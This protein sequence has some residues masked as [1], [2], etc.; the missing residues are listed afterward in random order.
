MSKGTSV[1][2]TEAAAAD[3]G[4]DGGGVDE[5]TALGAADGVDESSGAGDWF[6]GGAESGGGVEP[7]AATDAGATYGVEV[8]RRHMM[9]WH[10][11]S[12]SVCC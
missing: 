1:A 4:D 9:R 5:S 2:P 6:G 10:A 12:I 11:W 7:D 3:G 8:T